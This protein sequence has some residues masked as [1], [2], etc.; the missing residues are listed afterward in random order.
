MAG[1]LM[2]CDKSA[3]ITLSRFC[4][5]SDETLQK[6][7]ELK[8]KARPDHGSQNLID[9]TAF[10]SLSECFKV[11]DL[12]HELVETTEAV[13]LATECVINEFSEDNVIYLEL[14][15]TPRETEFMTKAQCLQTIIDTIKS[16][17]KSPPSHNFHI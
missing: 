8:K 2:T 3:V 1:K 9:L 16:E 11:F 13:K 14:R 10:R 7:V 4:S 5:L 17:Q 12:A 6:L 15:S